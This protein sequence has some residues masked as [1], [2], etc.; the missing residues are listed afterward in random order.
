M[1]IFIEI[2]TFLFGVLI[3]PILAFLTLYKVLK[4]ERYKLRKISLIIICTI[5]PAFTGMKYNLM[6]KLLTITF[7][8][9]KQR[10]YPIKKS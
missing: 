4:S 7:L 10:I 2:T 5:F 3:C 1:I 8:L 9:Y 6:S